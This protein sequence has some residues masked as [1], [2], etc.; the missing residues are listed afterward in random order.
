MSIICDV[1]CQNV[2]VNVFS[3]RPGVTFVSEDPMRALHR[4]IVE[5]VQRP[6]EVTLHILHVD[7]IG[8]MRR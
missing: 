4:F 3:G 6:R 7:D 2:C 5:V 8:D 1:F